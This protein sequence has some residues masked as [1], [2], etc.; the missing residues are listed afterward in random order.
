M[1]KASTPTVLPL[2][3]LLRSYRERMPGIG[4][5]GKLPVLG[6]R[7]AAVLAASARFTHWP[8]DW[9]RRARGL[10]GLKR[11]LIL[12]GVPGTGKTHRGPQ[13]GPALDR[14]PR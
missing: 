7:F 13:P 9:L 4:E 6:T 11:Q 14:R 3:P 12:Q 1:I 5:M 10:L 2:V 8:A